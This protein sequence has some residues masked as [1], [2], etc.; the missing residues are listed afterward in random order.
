MN[1]EELD[2]KDCNSL[3]AVFD[4]KGE[5]TEEIAVQNSTQLKKLKLFNLPKLKHVWKED[6]HYTMRKSRILINMLNETI[7][8][9]RTF[10]LKKIYPH[11]C[12]IFRKKVFGEHYNIP[13]NL[14]N[15][16]YNR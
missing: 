3:E 6:P 13:R 11:I 14:K 12:K 16:D 5:F 7:I 9:P 10:S 15:R 2:V 4:L 1:L 8:Y